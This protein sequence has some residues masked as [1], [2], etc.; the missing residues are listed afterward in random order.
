MIF[1]YGETVTL[2]NRV[3]SGRD[4]YGN[5][6]F[7]EVTTTVPKVP[8]WP[9]T[10]SEAVQGEDVITTGLT[11][12]LPAGTAVDAVD[13]VIIYGVPHEVDGEPGLYRS[14]FTPSA[15]GVVVNLRRV[16]G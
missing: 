7:T 8:V 16:T 5:D 12:L 10:S 14:P 4:S 3:V 11:M 6:V 1:T 2:V 9:R 13:K 15:A